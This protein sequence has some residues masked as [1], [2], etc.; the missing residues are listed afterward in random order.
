[1]H[2]R[3]QFGKIAM[4]TLPAYSALGKIA[5]KIHGVRIGVAGYS[6][7]ALPRQGLLDVIVASMVDSGIGDCLLFAPSTEPVE[8]ADKA[9][10]ARGGGAG[11][12][13][14]GRGVS[15]GSG[16]NGR[17][18][19]GSGGGARGG[20]RGPVSPEQAAALEALHQWHLTVP[21]TYYT[22]IRNKFSAAGLEI[23]SFD[24]SLGNTTSDEDLNRACEVT[25]ALGADCMMCAVTR[26]VAKRL[27]PIAA[28]HSLRVAFQGRPNINSTDPDV[29]AK[30][31][32][33]EE[34]MSYSKNFGSSIDVGDA[35]GAGWDVLK[36]IQDTHSRVFGLNLKDR[37]KA[38][39]SMPWGQGDSQI[40]EILQL[41]RTKKYPIRCYIDCDYAVAEGS[42][43]VG[44]VKRCMEFARA[45][46][47]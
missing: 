42:T 4:V 20:G 5:P 40:K 45:A 12:A 34:A 11:G 9:R 26:S 16:G 46:L 24:A 29:M 22:A 23:N 43:R 39:V 31:A 7:N 33:F 44:E 28:K 19:G 38:N 13:G 37:T 3:R 36:F 47:A 18:A 6:Y 17:S 15:G 10:P 21:L 41:V 32:D 30:P 25:K 1:M 8:L 14:F 35:T 2:T 27:A